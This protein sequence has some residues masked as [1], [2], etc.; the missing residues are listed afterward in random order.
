MVELCRV[1]QARPGMFESV[2]RAVV[3]LGSAALIGLFL[4]VLAIA[5]AVAVVRVLFFRAPSNS[6]AAHSRPE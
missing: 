4:W 3:V 6:S 2:R 5:S 1:E